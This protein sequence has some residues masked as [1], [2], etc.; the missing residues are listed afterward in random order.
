[1]AKQVVRKNKQSMLIRDSA[2]MFESKK[3]RGGDQAGRN[4]LSG[5]K[6]VFSWMSKEANAQSNVSWS[7]INTKRGVKYV[8]KKKTMFASL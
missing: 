3:V 4:I 8:P 2:A 1:M 5:K 6:G 7:R